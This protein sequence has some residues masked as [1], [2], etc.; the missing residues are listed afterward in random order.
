MDIINYN[1]INVQ[2]V[3][4]AYPS[5]VNVSFK[6]INDFIGMGIDITFIEALSSLQDTTVNNYTNLYLSDQ[7]AVPNFLEAKTPK[8]IYPIYRTTYLNPVG[9]ATYCVI[10]SSTGTVRVSGT[11]NEIDNRY[12]YELE[13]LSTDYMAVRTTTVQI[14]NI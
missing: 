7:K 8:Q 3:S 2:P 14:L 1:P 12:F 13:I 4:A 10:D 5:D 11:E 9:S 6:N